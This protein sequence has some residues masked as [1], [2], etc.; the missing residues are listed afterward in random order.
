MWAIPKRRCGFFF[1]RRRR[2][3]N[4]KDT[5]LPYMVKRRGVGAG[6]KRQ[7]RHRHPSRFD[8]LISFWFRRLVFPDSDKKLLILLP[9]SLRVETTT[10]SK[11]KWRAGWLR[12]HRGQDF[13][14]STGPFLVVVL[15]CVFGD[16]SYND[17]CYYYYLHCCKFLERERERQKYIKGERSRRCW[18]EIF[19]TG[20]A[21]KLSFSS[22]TNTKLTI[23]SHVPSTAPKSDGF[24]FLFNQKR[25]KQRREELCSVWTLF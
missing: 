1:C 13:S 6:V 23:L 7:Q 11:R 14:Q 5:L 17:N 15:V 18:K 9:L 25:K 12:S 24:F 22:R 10:L 16:E 19:Q 2:T 8:T 4:K 3:Q 21:W 20:A